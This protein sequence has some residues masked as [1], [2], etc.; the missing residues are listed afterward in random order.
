[1]VMRPLEPRELLERCD[2]AGEAQVLDIKSATIGH[3]MIARLRFT[4][5]VKGSVQRSQKGKRNVAVVALRDRAE[6]SSGEVVLGAWSD[7]YEPGMTVFTHLDW[8]AAASTYHTTW[9][10]AV[11]PVDREIKQG[12]WSHLSLIVDSCN[13]GRPRKE[14]P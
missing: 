3:G 1:M 9:W 14:S 4:Q 10:N 6:T 7:S 11:T 13:L 2:L 8:D 5:I 12:F